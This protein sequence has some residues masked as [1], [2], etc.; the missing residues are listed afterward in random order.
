LRRHIAAERHYFRRRHATRYD[1]ARHAIFAYFRYFTLLLIYA[2]AACRHR[3]D[4]RQPADFTILFADDIDARPPSRHFA[5]RWRD[6][7]RVDTAAAAPLVAG[8]R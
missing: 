7:L 8:S 6:S 1:I 4:F 3:A 5:A 2:D